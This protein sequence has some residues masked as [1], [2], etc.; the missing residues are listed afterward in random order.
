MNFTILFTL[1]TT[2]CLGLY[3]DENTTGNAEPVAL[4]HANAD[5][6]VADHNPN[7]SLDPHAHG[8]SYSLGIEVTH[9]HLI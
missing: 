5:A 2:G 7:S 1:P 8:I 6:L 4:A 3:E 9:A